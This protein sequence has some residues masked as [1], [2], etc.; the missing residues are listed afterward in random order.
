MTTEAHWDDSRREKIALFRKAGLRLVHIEGSL[1]HH[2]SVD[3]FVAQTRAVLDGRTAIHGLKSS[4]Y[5]G[6]FAAKGED[7]APR[8]KKKMYPNGWRLRAGGR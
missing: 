3:A 1:L 8:G 2:K 7:M 5:R 4:S 6:L